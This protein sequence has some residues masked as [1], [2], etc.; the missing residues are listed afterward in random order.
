[1]KRSKSQQTI[2]GFFT[3]K[4]KEVEPEHVTSTEF[5]KK[6]Q[7]LE[8]AKEQICASATESESKHHRD[9][10]PGPSTLEV[11]HHEQ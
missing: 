2:T 6:H 4:N 3:K 7:E 8:I 1:M 5:A 10:H 9:I 11:H